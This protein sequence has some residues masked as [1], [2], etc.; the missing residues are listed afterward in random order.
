[1]RAVIAAAEVGDDVFGEDPSVNRLQARVAEL[2]G[3]EASLFVPSGTMANQLALKSQTN[4]GDEVFLER[5]SHIFNYES[6][7]PG[8]LSGVQLHVLDGAAG[9]LSG[10]QIAAAV[11]HGYYWESPGRLLCL[12]NTINRTGGTVYPFDRLIEVTAAAREAGLATHLDGARLWN[13][14]VATGI[15]E[16]DY[17]ALF[18]TVT[19]C[20]SKGLGAPVGSLLA[21]SEATV[22]RAH[23]YRKMFG[24]GMRQAGILAAAG[25]F[26]LEHNRADLRKDHENTRR[27][28]ECIGR[29]SAS[30]HV[31]MTRVQTNILTFHVLDGD[32]YATVDRLRERGVL[33]LPWG[34]DMIRVTLHRDVAAEDVS[35]AIDIFDELYG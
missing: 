2:L 7:G 23:R 14:S 1:M 24:G 29:L 20:L 33:V 26:A 9:V 3:K 15:P 31:D 8:L 18:D 25:S 10:Q 16:A 28:A 32:S 12:E 4:P 34:P 22:A 17:A 21:G 11:R 13:A 19:V 6:G 30:F 35:R 27:L 5:Q